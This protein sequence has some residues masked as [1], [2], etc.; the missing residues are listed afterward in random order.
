MELS[1]Y[2][3]GAVELWRADPPADAVALA[4]LGQ[5]GFAIR[6]GGLR[7]LIDPY[8]SDHLARKYAGTPMP[9]VRMMPPPLQADQIR[10]LDLVLCTHRHSDHMDPGSL[11]ELAANNPA[12]RFVVPRAEIEAAVRAGVPDDR[13]VPL[14][15]GES[16]VPA[17]GLE[18]LAIASA[19]PEPSTDERGLHRF[20][21][22]VLRGTGILPVRPTGVP[23]VEAG[24]GRPCD[25]WAGRPC[26]VTL[27]HSGDCVVYS[28][29]A[30]RLR[31][32]GVNLALLPVNGRSD[33][34]TARGVPGNMDFDEAV[35]LCRRA[36]IPAMIVHHFGMFDFNTADPADLRRRA[37]KLDER[38]LICIVPFVKEH[39]MAQGIPPSS[40]EAPASPR[41]A[42][43]QDQAPLLDPAERFFLDPASPVPLYHQIE[44]ILLERIAGR[45]AVGRLLPTEKDLMAMF[46]VSRATARKVYENLSGKGL[47]ERRR[48]LG[49]RVIAREISEDLGRLKSYT[50][51]MNLKGLKITTKLLEA[52]LHTPDERVAEKL[53]L[54]PGQ[55]TLQLRRLRGTDEV[56]PIVLLVSEIPASFGIDPTENFTGSLYKLIEEKYNIPIEFGD[57]E[58]RVAEAAG[59]EAKLLGVPAGKG[60]LVIERVTYARG[61]RPLEFVRGVYRPEHYT[62]SI[63]IRR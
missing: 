10:D 50:E 20:L 6:A 34:L 8:L 40:A 53:R 57:E 42:S 33:E 39:Y 11:G 59:E 19:H 51:E 15:D 47:V 3:G 26:H 9:H 49:T 31:E 27:Y 63:R 58:I 7:I 22:Y 28:G 37:A 14:N 62:F 13:L 35:A 56:F 46:A 44:Q 5:A 60:L 32:L 16:F 41:D 21:G 43:T 48:A 1:A 54:E 29:L 2:P 30:R 23:P 55:Q 61:E 36:R 25:A 18:V 12:C 45:N 24:P 4:W 38:R 52:R 17:D